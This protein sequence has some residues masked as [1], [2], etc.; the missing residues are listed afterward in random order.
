[1]GSNPFRVIPLLGISSPCRG[2]IFFMYKECLRRWLILEVDLE[3][4]RVVALV[5]LCTHVVELYK[6][7]I[8]CI[9][10]IYYLLKLLYIVG[11]YL[12]EYWFM[13]QSGRFYS[14]ICLL[15]L[16]ETCFVFG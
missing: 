6:F 13:G 11:I 14:C 12:D 1:M 9:R 8:C 7:D 5:L 15:M 3:E 10:I 16:I 2:N 4:S